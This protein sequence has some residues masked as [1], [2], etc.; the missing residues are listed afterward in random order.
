MVALLSG[1]APAGQSGGGSR[2]D[3]AALEH[4]G[5]WAEAGAA[6]RN[7]ALDAGPGKRDGAL[8]S[9]VVAFLM[10][11]QIDE[12]QRLVDEVLRRDPSF[13]EA[14]F[15]LA[16]GQ[17]VLQRYELALATLEKLLAQRPDH[18]AGQVSAGHVLLRLGRVAEAITRLESALQAA[19]L[20]ESLREQASL[21]LSRA[22]R[23]AGRAREAL[24]ALVAFLE[25]SPHHAVALNEAAQAAFALKKESLSQALR[26]HHQW[27]SARGHQLST[28]D[29]AALTS[30]GQ[31][32][33]GATAR[34]GLQAADRRE[35]RTALRILETVTANAP[36]DPLYVVPY[37]RLFV[38][39]SRHQDALRLLDRAEAGGLRDHAGLHAARAA[40]HAGMGE[41]AKAWD[42]HR[43]AGELLGRSVGKTPD[44]FGLLL[45]AV[46]HGIEWDRPAAE[47][48]PFLSLAEADGAQAPQVGL[49]RA[50]LATRER[51]L[52]RVKLAV[53]TLAGRLSQESE[54]LRRLRAVEA[55]LDGDLKTAA[56][57]IM[58]LRSAEPH[59]LRNYEAFE[60]VFHTQRGESLVQQVLHLRDALMAKRAALEGLAR[61]AAA[62]PLEASH[63]ELVA[64]AKSCAELGERE[65]AI[66]LFFLAAE[67]DPKDSESLRRAEGLLLAPG[68]FTQRLWTLRRLF[69]RA[70]D[71]VATRRALVEVYLAEGI[72]LVTAAALSEEI[73]RLKPCP[74]SDELVARARASVKA[75]E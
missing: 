12:A 68:E 24:D 72:R 46:H 21:D 1:C 30:S 64:L 18:L 71:D 61:D 74:E 11:D 56:R 33:E 9:A 69:V 4:E 8:R 44:P 3:P 43:R 15:Y 58:A 63:D 31:R 23:R 53:E 34:T 37:A 5:R 41:R 29:P 48:E 47:I 39:L 27:L 49:A 52:P 40:A 28:E 38:R 32:D 13:L 19:G 6:H 20:S 10:A 35:F 26:K 42:A 16:D 60:A 22:L 36:V 75:A 57:E 14:L 50:R 62:K 51:D 7:L 17:R 73:A 70:P 54:E 45:Q 2:P 55:G 67:L 66:D 25:T 59:E 65:A